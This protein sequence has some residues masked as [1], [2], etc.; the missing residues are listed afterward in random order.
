MHQAWVESGGFTPGTLGRMIQCVCFIASTGG[1]TGGAV[2]W[3]NRN[4][5]MQTTTD[6]VGTGNSGTGAGGATHT[7]GG[8]V[9]FSSTDNWQFGAYTSA[10]I[11]V[12]YLDNSGSTFLKASAISAANSGTNVNA[13]AGRTG[14]MTGWG[15]YFIV[16]VYVRRSGTWVKSFIYIRRS[17][18]WALPATYIWRSG[19]T[20]VGRLIQPNQLDWKREQKAI[21][22]YPD[23]TWEP[24]LLR[25]DYDR[26]RYAGFGYPG[27]PRI[28]VPSAPRPYELAA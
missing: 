4:A 23:G 6:G 13:Y 9:P 26:P 14:Q 2:A 12:N 17:S 11:F 25:W 28:I 24:A 3:Q 22:V 18:A 5:V 10:G 7:T 20:Q 16:E 27:D 21:Q 8:D 19:W 1:G 15:T